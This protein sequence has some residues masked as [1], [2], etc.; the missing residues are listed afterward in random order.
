MGYDD[1]GTH[2]RHLQVIRAA[3]S[4]QPYS[5]PARRLILQV[6]EEAARTKHDVADL[7]NVAIEELSRQRWELP[8]FVTLHRAARHVRAVV[9]RRYYQR[10]AE[11]VSR[12]TPDRL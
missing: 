6:M 1:S 8:A 4:V 11:A 5:H 3:L 12:A 7:I 2:H 9:A 10:I